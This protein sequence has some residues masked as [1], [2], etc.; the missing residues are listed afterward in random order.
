[1]NCF[2]ITVFIHVVKELVLPYKEKVIYS[3]DSEVLVCTLVCNHQYVL[4]DS[5]HTATLIQFKNYFL[6]IIMNLVKVK[7][8]SSLSESLQ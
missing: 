1:M 8:N 3:L 4:L 7:T 2:V 6:V 5:R